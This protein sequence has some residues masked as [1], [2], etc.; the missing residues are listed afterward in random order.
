MD[1]EHVYK[2]LAQ[3]PNLRPSCRDSH[4]GGAN[5]WTMSTV[6]IL[7]LLC[8]FTFV[9]KKFQPCL[10]PNSPSNWIQY[11]DIYFLKGTFVVV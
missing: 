2:D 3:C 9:K 1:K 8:C 11:R 6:N 7:A 5:S 10:R 4:A